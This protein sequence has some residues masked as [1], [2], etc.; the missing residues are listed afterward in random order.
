[1]AAKAI[2][3][4]GEFHRAGFRRVCNRQ[5]A[6]FTDLWYVVS[7]VRPENWMC[8][9][10]SIPLIF[11]LSEVLRSGLRVDLNP[12]CDFA[13]R[14]SGLFIIAYRVNSRKG[15]LH[16]VTLPR[17][18]F[19]NLI[20]PGTVLGK[21][22]STFLMFAS[23]MM[24]LMQRIDAKVQRYRTGSTSDTGEQFIADGTRLTGLAGPL[25]IARM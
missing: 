16:N 25:Y 20:L 13:E 21:D 8:G 19:I 4:R 3:P 24:E 22:T 18:W 7:T 14:L 5:I 9:S 12:L 17:S 1:V 15:V 10:T 23:T 2:S 6:S 11:P